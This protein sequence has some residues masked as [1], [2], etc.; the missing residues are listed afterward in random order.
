[1]PTAQDDVGGLCVQVITLTEFLPALGVTMEGLEAAAMK[2]FVVDGIFATAEFSIAYRLG[3]D[4]IPHFI[5]DAPNGFQ[6]FALFNSD[7]CPMNVV[8]S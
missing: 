1:M 3:H 5:G 2:G 8:K 6:T 7:V 4:I